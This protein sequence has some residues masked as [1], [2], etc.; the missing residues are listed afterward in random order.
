MSKKAADIGI[1]VTKVTKVKCLISTVEIVILL[2]LARD[3]SGITTEFLFH[4]CPLR[5]SKGKRIEENF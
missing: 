5:G 2:G 3:T 4:L 1:K